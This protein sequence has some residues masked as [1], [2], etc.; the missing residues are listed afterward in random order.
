VIRGINYP[1]TVFDGRAN[2]GCDFGRNKWS[3]HTGVTAHLDDVRADFK[4]MSGA[5]VEVAR[6]FVFTD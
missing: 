1:W 2:Y 3:S 4:A 5:G 6:W